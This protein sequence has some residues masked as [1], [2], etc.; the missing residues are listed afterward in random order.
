M[1]EQIMFFALG[2]LIATLVALLVLPA[3]WHRAVRLT[4][5]RVEAAVPVSIFEI[6]AD[7]D[8]QRAAFALNQRR[9]ELQ[10]DQTRET[11]VSHAA[12]IEKQR[13]RI[14]DLDKQLTQKTAEHDALTLAHADL[15]ARFEAEAAALVDRT[16]SLDQAT[17]TLAATRAALAA[18]STSLAEQTARSDELQV[19]LAASETTLLHRDGR[20][21]ELERDLTQE[22]T[23]H[24][25]TTSALGDARKLLFDAQVQA[26]EAATK[27]AGVETKLNAE[28]SQTR[29]ALME[30]IA[31]SADRGT[32]L[33]SQAARI[34]ELEA[35]LALMTADFEANQ[36]IL[37]TLQHQR[38]EEFA[39]AQA[40]TRR[41]SEALQMLKADHAMMADALE[42]AR[43][44]RDEVPG[45]MSEP[46]RAALKAAISA[47]A[48]DIAGRA[49]REP[50]SPLPAILT[51]EDAAEGAAAPVSLAARIRAVAAR[52]D[53]APAAPEAQDLGSAPVTVPHQMAGE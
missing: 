20:I 39:A 11:I 14:F 1:I 23:A 24:T 33:A 48:A 31:E 30:K 9:L 37:Q 27:A 15:T 45:A 6:Q 2:V 28:L 3:V 32:T 4:T 51:R 12:A 47:L 49:A 26:T 17:A 35:A 34:T 5:R 53:T 8:Q 13:L 29:R 52:D 10:L 44:A 36:S 38:A 43:A 16:L 25:E 22:R 21:T 18:T 19:S 40:E 46:E 7:K 41:L 50:D 42:R